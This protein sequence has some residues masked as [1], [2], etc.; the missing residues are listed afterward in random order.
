[1]QQKKS[2][3]LTKKRADNLFVFGM[4]LL[5]FINFIVFYLYVNFDS[6]L[7]AFQVPIGNE[8]KWGFENFKTMFIEFSSSSGALTIA[9]KNTFIYFFSG[10]FITLPLSFF[11]CYFLYKKVFGYKAYRVIFYL[12]SIISASVLVAL[13]KYFIATN[14]LL[15]HWLV[16]LGFGDLPPVFESKK[17]ATSVINFYTI[18]FGLGGNL[19][20]FSGAMNNID[21]GII[22]AAKIDG[23]GMLTEMFKIVI[24]LMWPTLSTV[25]IFQ[26]IGIFNASG[27]ILLFNE[28]AGLADTWT[29]NYW[30]YSQVRAGQSLNYPSAVGMFFTVIGAPIALFMRWLL[31]RFFDY[32][33]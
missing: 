7:M 32:E 16:Q 3:E 21:S 8:F 5:P 18:F 11:L 19:V 26:F 10:L 30:I 28:D 13:F 12:P 2:F 20:L 9:L 31:T 27:P 33:S 14:G 23:A 15:D 22:E 17:L 24:P 29:I 4:L 6:F 1:M 25:M